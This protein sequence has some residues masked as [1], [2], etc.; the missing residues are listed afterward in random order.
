MQLLFD[1][2]QLNVS[3]GTCFYQVLAPYF[4]KVNMLRLCALQ[5]LS[6]DRLC[7]SGEYVTGFFAE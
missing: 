1:P 7:N 5:K 6:M 3:Q 2:G 4:D